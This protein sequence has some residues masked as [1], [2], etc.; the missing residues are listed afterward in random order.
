MP[1]K[2]LSTSL[3]DSRPNTSSLFNTSSDDLADERDDATDAVE[4]GTVAVEVAAREVGG[5][6]RTMIQR[7]LVGATTISYSAVTKLSSSYTHDA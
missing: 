6:L 7:H 4:V 1:V 5:R 3:I 2:N